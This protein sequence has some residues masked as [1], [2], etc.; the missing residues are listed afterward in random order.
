MQNRNTIERDATA[1]SLK[2]LRIRADLKQSEL[3]ERAGVSQTDISYWETNGLWNVSCKRVKR[4]AD[5]LRCSMDDFFASDGCTPETDE[6][7][8][9]A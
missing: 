1:I 4:L 8:T 9:V 5:A 7:K 2:I 6:R 3:A